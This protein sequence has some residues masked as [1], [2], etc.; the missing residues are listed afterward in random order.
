[1]Q[2]LYP[3]LSPEAVI[4]WANL[5]L[6]S[7]EAKTFK[8]AKTKIVDSLIKISKALEKD[9]SLVKEFKNFRK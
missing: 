2:P 6:L 4:A 7:L 9:P 8:K 3:N 1:M 5:E